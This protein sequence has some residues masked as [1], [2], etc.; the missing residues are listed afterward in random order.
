MAERRGPGQQFAPYVQMASRHKYTGVAA[1][2]GGVVREGGT[3]FTARGNNLDACSL[4]LPA[5]DACTMPPFMCASTHRHSCARAHALARAPLPAHRGT[6]VPA[7]PAHARIH[8]KPTSSI[9]R[10]QNVNQLRWGEEEVLA[11]QER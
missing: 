3:D 11:A 10:V 2:A 7:A 1:W 4:L 6:S 8:A 9:S 5:L